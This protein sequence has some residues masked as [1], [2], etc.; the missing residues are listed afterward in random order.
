MTDFRAKFHVLAVTAH[1]P[2]TSASQGE[3]YRVLADFYR[4][5]LAEI[6]QFPPFK[7]P[8]SVLDIPGFLTSFL[9]RLSLVLST[10]G[11]ALGIGCST[12][13]FRLTSPLARVLPDIACGTTRLGSFGG[14]P[15]CPVRHQKKNHRYPTKRPVLSHNLISRNSMPDFKYS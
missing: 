13:L 1:G 2:K 10:T 9:L 5:R 14:R 8:R 3:K 15:S 7:R 4:P 11:I 12:I 6:G